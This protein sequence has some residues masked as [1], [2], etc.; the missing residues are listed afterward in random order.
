MFLPVGKHKP[1]NM[2][3][4]TCPVHNRLELINASLPSSNSPNKDRQSNFSNNPMRLV[5][6][7][8][9][10]QGL[11]RDKTHSRLNA[12]WWMPSGSNFLV[13]FAVCN[14]LLHCF[15]PMS[16]AYSP[17]Y[18]KICSR[19]DATIG[20]FGFC[21]ASAASEVDS[22]RMNSNT[23]PLKTRASGEQGCM[24]VGCKGAWA[25]SS[26]N[27]WQNQDL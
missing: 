16:A 13:G 12:A 26:Q 24:L 10:L 3:H 6:S 20:Y 9:L 21:P 7:G 19:H 8:G 14:D 2:I 23:E 15:G 25:V 22:G 4:T 5:S 18:V 27:R 17:F 11:V 1:M